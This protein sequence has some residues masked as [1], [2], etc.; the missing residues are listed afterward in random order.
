M[1]DKNLSVD[2][3]IMQELAEHDLTLCDL[4]DEQIAQFKEEIS[5]WQSGGFVLDGV[6]SELSFIHMNKMTQEIANSRNGIMNNSRI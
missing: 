3:I 2:E 5:I 4:T 1:Y 6:A